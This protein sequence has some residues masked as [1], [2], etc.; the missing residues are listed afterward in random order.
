[1]VDLRVEYCRKRIAEFERARAWLDENHAPECVRDCPYRSEKA[2]DIQ[3]CCEELQLAAMG[4]LDRLFLYTNDFDFV[5]LCRTLRQLGCNI[6]LF[7]LK[8]PAVNAD[9]AKECDAFHEMDDAR[10][11]GMLYDATRTG[12]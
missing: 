10:P 5:P 12:N 4:R 3:I 1:V 6:N 7:R 2:V 8:A 11:R 9:L